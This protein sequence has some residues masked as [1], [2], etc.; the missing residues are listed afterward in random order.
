[1]RAMKQV[2]VAL[3]G[4]G[5]LATLG[6][7]CTAGVEL[8]AIGV[9]EG[10]NTFCL[11]A[12][13]LLT[14]NEVVAC[15]AKTNN[16][17]IFASID[18]KDVAE[19]YSGSRWIALSEHMKLLDAYKAMSDDQ[20]AAAAVAFEQTDAGKAVVY[21]ALSFFFNPIKDDLTAPPS[22]TT[23]VPYDGI[24][25]DLSEAKLAMAKE[26]VAYWESPAFAFVL[27]VGQWKA[28]APLVNAKTNLKKLSFK[29]QNHAEVDQALGDTPSLSGANISVLL[30][31]PDATRSS[32]VSGYGEKVAMADGAAFSE[33][34]SACLFKPGFH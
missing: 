7:Y 10:R 16:A 18:L 4:G 31:T 1:M 17:P 26:V 25:L 15:K 24:V 8:I 23:K 12:S 20:L 3:L 13:C 11:Q 29:A 19:G 33:A 9:S 30:P 32:R 27:Q 14:K 2:L 28:L 22:D 5:A 6:D 34:W 21:F